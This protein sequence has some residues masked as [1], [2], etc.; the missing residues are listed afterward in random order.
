MKIAGAVLA[1]GSS[2]RLGRA[3]QLVPH[4]GTTLVHATATC[5]LEA[6]DVVAVIVG[7]RGDAVAGALRD[8]PV[9]IVWNFGWREGMASSIRCAAEWATTTGASALALVVCDQPRLTATH[10][11][12]LVDAHRTTSATIASRYQGR[13]G[14]P[15]VLG[16]VRFGDLLALTGDRGA[17]D[18]LAGAGAIDWPDGAIDVDVP[19]HLDLVR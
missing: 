15:A 9:E 7:A 12:E 10:L 13:L 14:V 11:R 3:K 6:C 8:L 18:L 19:A 4:R 1:A 17:R 5:A 16:H 2:S